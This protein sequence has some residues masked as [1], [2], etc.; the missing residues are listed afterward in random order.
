MCSL[1]FIICLG[2]PLLFL[3][4]CLTCH[5]PSFASWI[6][7]PSTCHNQRRVTI[8]IEAI[9][10]SIR[11]RTMARARIM[12]RLLVLA[13]AT[14]TAMAQTQST[15][16]TATT[17]PSSTITSSASSI[18]ATA[19]ASSSSDVPLELWSIADSLLS[20]Y[21]PSTTLT[22][23]ASLTWPTAVVIG[24]ATYSVHSGTTGG[25]IG[26][27]P[28]TS[29]LAETTSTGDSKASHKK[30]HGDEELGIV[31]AAVVGA[32]VLTVFGI[33]FCCLW[34][35][36]RAT[37]AFFHRRP[38][39]SI[40]DSDINTW[41][42]PMI[43]DASGMSSGPSH[44]W[45]EKYNRMPV[46]ERELQPPMAMHPA[47]MRHSSSRSTS[48]DN[49]FFTPQERSEHYEMEGEQ[50][51]HNEL[52]AG[53]AAEVSQRR[54]SSSPMRQTSRPPT[55]FSPMAMMAL[56]S[57]QQRQENPFRSQEDEE[58]DDVISPIVPARSPERRHSPMVHYPSWS[59]VSE[60]DFSG[61]G[62]YR[63]SVR[64]QSSGEE[65]GED[66]WRPRRESVLGRHELA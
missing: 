3:W 37:G 66:G 19:S 65:D 55:P 32:V 12:N 17:S 15:T 53:A 10:L 8:R 39:P 48:E 27:T 50:T 51:R 29:V 25:M 43:Q 38:T 9:P 45:T 62:K 33:V 1:S 31:I 5:L 42:S 16:P 61:D 11:Q 34:R 44:D 64:G 24:S 46:A 41:R 21:Y 54:R 7:S 35:R 58:A 22:Q 57:H 18:T 4:P 49:P 30:K 26:G 13:L 63:R 36:R 28:A 14:T 60:F 52:G 59:E 47:Y 2:L 56:S 6:L 20:S 23:V 40:S